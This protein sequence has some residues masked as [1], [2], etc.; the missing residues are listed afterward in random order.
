[1][2]SFDLVVVSTSGGKD[3]QVAL[4]VT[5]AQCRAAGVLDR[6]VV[7]HADLG[8]DEWPGTTDLVRAQCAH[9]GVPLVVCSRI[10]QIKTDSNGALYAKGET[11][12]DMH[13][14]V[15]RRKAAHVRGQ[16]A[17]K[18]AWYSPAVRFCTSEFKRSPIRSATQRI[19]DE[20]RKAAPGRTKRA[21]R[22][23][24]VQGLRADESSRRAKRV[25]LEKDDGFSSSRREV[26]T[27]LP[28]HGWTADDVWSTIRD[29]G[30]PYHWAYDVGMPRLSCS[31]CI[32]AP[33]EALVLAGHYNRQRLLEK[34]QLEEA[35]GD[36][37][38]ADLALADVLEE[39]DAGRWPGVT[40]WVM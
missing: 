1:L 32:F 23:L 6:L 34:V 35:T 38:K 21:C 24:S 31:L 11:F 12:G 14:Y 18:P 19:I 30:V 16:Q 5:V 25:P 39:V 36:T 10:G 8:A 2:A 26:W 40:D 17:S 27:W 7:V 33:R 9:Y 29:S 22:V 20:W 28:V 3:S 15:S 4:D 13:D 37:F